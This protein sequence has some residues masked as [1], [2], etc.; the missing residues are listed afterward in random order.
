M[1][2]VKNSYTFLAFGV[3]I[4]LMLGIIIGLL[5]NRDNKYMEKNDTNTALEKVKNENENKTSDD[6]KKED[7]TTKSEVVKNETETKKNT[8]NSSTKTDTSASAKTEVKEEPIK[9]VTK[10][11][12]STS[13]SSTPS[14]TYSANDNKVI[15][16]LNDTLTEVNKASNDANFSKKAKA[17]FISLVDFLFYDGQING[18]TF[19][20][21]TTSGKEKVLELAQKIDAALEKKA[22]GYK[23]TISSGASKA[24]NKASEVIKNGAANIN[25]FAR[26]KLGEEYYQQ[27]I[28]EK[29]ELVKYTKNAAGFLKSVGGSLFSSLKDKLN[30]VYQNFKNSN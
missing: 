17:T 13:S 30:D 19:K 10:K 4:I 12:E 11:T 7:T 25:N 5:I 29:D 8:T 1:R 16:T 9:E 6:S 18:V 26:E 20:E 15:N 22:P 23:D 14:V 27:I 21:L 28:D 3:V 24:F 2:E